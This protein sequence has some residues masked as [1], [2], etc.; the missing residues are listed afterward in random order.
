MRLTSSG[1]PVGGTDTT[2]IWGAS[3][4]TASSVAFG[5]LR[6]S[7]LHDA[8]WSARSIASRSARLSFSRTTRMQA[9]SRG[10][11]RQLLGRRDEH[12]R[13]E[14]F[15]DPTLGPERLGAL[16]ELRLALGRQHDDGDARPLG[17]Q[18]LEELDAVHARHVH[19]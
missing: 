18:S 9:G 4:E 19:V 11:D 5:S 1:P 15:D 7:T 3:R 10:D 14:G 12:L 8:S 16:D 2:M 6:G 17:A 13:L